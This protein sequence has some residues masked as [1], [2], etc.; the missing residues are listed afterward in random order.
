MAPFF[1]MASASLPASWAYC[2]LHQ[3]LE[4]VAIAHPVTKVSWFFLAKA[5]TLL[6]VALR[7]TLA[8]QSSMATLFSSLE[9]GLLV[10]PNMA[11]IDWQMRSGFLQIVKMQLSPGSYPKGES[12]GNWICT[13]H[14][15]LRRLYYVNVA[16]YIICC[17]RPEV[18]PTKTT[19]DRPYA[20]P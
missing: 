8:L 4:V 20:Q 2:R 7:G 11:E 18:E 3:L 9:K 6:K 19:Y 15:L 16:M 1:S 10:F 12:Q 17:R 13:G 14:V 5:K